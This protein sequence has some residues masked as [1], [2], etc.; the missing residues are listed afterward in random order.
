MSGDE[1]REALAKVVTEHLECFDTVMN[2]RAESLGIADRLLA[3][4]LIP[5]PVTEWEEV[6]P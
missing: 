6:Q 4:G 5:A 2:V 3:S 1:T